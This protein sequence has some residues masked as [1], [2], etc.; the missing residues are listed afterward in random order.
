MGGNVIVIVSKADWDEKL[1][2]AAKEGKGVIVDFFATWC[3][4]C[5]FIAPTFE[6]FSNSFTDTVFL[7]V[8]VDAAQEVAANVGITAMPTFH[9]YKNGQKVGEVVGA[10][11]AGLE[12]LIE[13]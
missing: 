2:A 11:K 7:K 8:D 9:G 13:Q 12:K 1:A 5:H 4:P 6:E 3:G 10:N